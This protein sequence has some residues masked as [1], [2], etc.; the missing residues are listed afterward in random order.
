MPKRFRTNRASPDW[1]PT[2][3]ELQF[4]L[5][6]ELAAEEAS[7]VRL[8]LEACWSCRVR[9]EKVQETIAAFID[10]RTQ[11]LE[12]LPED[13]NHWRTFRPRLRASVEESGRRPML[14]AWREALTES[15]RTSRLRWAVVSG[16]VV[17]IMAALLFTQLA[18]VRVASASELL[19]RSAELRAAQI[20]AV[21]KPIVYQHLHVR[22]MV[23]APSNLPL[24]D[25][26]A[27]VEIWADPLG[28][29]VRVAGQ[30]WSEVS[31]ASSN[32][33][34]PSSRV[35]KPHSEA[36]RAFVVWKGLEET[37]RV[38]RMD[39]RQ[40]LSAAS[41]ETWRGG[42]EDK[43]E[44]VEA[45]V[46]PNGAQVLKLW[47]TARGAVPIGGIAEAGLVLQAS[48]LHPI[49]GTLGVRQEEGYCHYDLEEMS[50]RLVTLEALPH[51]I[52][53]EPGLPALAGPVTGGAPPPTRALPSASELAATEMQARIGL[54]GVAADL[55]EPIEIV[56]T[57]LEVEV[58]GLVD[59]D[60]RKKD[61]V[62]ALQGIPHLVMKV[63][64]VAEAGKSPPV[65]SPENV[66]EPR[67]Q[68]APGLTSV[69]R[70]VSSP[71]LP[72]QEQLEKYLSEHRSTTVS[73]GG[74]ENGATE[75]TIQH[76]IQKLTTQAVTLS[77]AS[78]EHA[79]ALRRLAERYTP[80]E[81]ST[82]PPESRR[83][84]ED[85]V[86]DHIRALREQNRKYGTLVEPA[87]FW[88]AGKPEGASPSST[89]QAEADWPVFSPSL[90]N[91]VSQVDRLT[92]TLF[93][94]AALPVEADS[95][96]PGARGVKT[97]SP[98][99]CV[100]DLLAALSL[101]DTELPRLEKQV[102]GDFLGNR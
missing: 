64:T 101:L 54:H 100:R 93:A 19:S 56:R 51:D 27:T 85:L 98:E 40:P 73:Q 17:T 4:Y 62:V 2:D 24:D 9:A 81:V 1:H 58:R 97:K 32:R 26:S 16:V 28:A 55:G 59:T 46:L 75:G 102:E 69:A 34:T 41:Y 71:K 49:G 5:D 92:S 82:L 18:K 66:S 10:Y 53:G 35:A 48:D 57:R 44:R 7:Q 76:D 42:L 45:S 83:Q 37:Y 23:V 38:N 72:I 68:A 60:Q 61:L 78:L 13:P 91:T 21:P 50:F 99:A 43:D 63:L 12:A 88:I 6:G 36:G 65:S 96:L 77:E 31:G 29:Q 70:A 8:H 20:R 95:T 15:F 11:M 52:F 90:F 30:G 67:S 84:L 14:I 33:P 80:D 87:L 22:R 3:A 39:W 79:W 74:K 94:G 47:T 25:Q 89:G 86:R